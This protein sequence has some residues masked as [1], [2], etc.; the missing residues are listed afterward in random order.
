MGTVYKQSHKGRTEHVQTCEKMLNSR[1]IDMQMET[2]HYIS[3]SLN[4]KKK[5]VNTNW[6]QRVLADIIKASLCKNMFEDIY[7]PFNLQ[8][9]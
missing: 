8:I 4:N 7:C 6:W 1:V 3:C 2:V 9:Q 5:F